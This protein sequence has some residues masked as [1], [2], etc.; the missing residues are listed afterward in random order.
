MPIETF[1]EVVFAPED[2]VY[3]ALAD[4]W[5]ARNKRHRGQGFGFI[6]FRHDK[7]NFE[8]VIPVEIL[9]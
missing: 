7:S 6:A 1:I 5:I 4:L 2:V 3:D 8:G 9:Q